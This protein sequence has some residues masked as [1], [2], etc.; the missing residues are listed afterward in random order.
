MYVQKH[1]YFISGV[2]MLVFKLVGPHA[3]THK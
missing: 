2:S 3:H 1:I